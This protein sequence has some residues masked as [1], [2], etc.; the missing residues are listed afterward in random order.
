MMITASHNPKE[1]NGFKFSYNGI[2]NAYGDSVKEIYEIIVN[3]KFAKGDGVIE[4]CDIREAYINLVI[5]KLKFGKR[6]VNEYPWTGSG[7][8]KIPGLEKEV[9]E[10]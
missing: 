8:G 6:K 3:G 10:C 5:D 9:A 7:T 4:F 1:Y 2:H